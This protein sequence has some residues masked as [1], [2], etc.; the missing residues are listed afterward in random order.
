MVQSFLTFLQEKNLRKQSQELVWRDISTQTIVHPDKIER[1]EEKQLQLEIKCFVETKNDVFPL[2]IEDPL[3]LFSDVGIVVHENDK[4]Y[5][6]HIGKKII[7]PVINKSIPIFGEENIDTIKDNGI[8]R[9]NPFFSAQ[10]LERVKAYG[11]TTN[12]NYIDD[13]GHFS[14]KVANFG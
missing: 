4:R 13:Q 2:I 1:K 9:L 3:L 7:I 11:L 12:E 6:K 10:D 8:Q 14:E 5:K